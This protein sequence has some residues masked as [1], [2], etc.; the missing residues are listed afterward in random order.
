MHGLLRTQGAVD[1]E[2]LNHHHTCKSQLQKLL[3]ALTETILVRLGYKEKG[4]A[5]QYKRQADGAHP[6]WS[7]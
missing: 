7:G 1:V 4:K 3:L 6:S 5:E 2:M